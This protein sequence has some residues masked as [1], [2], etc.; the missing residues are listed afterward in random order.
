MALK[1][2]AAEYLAEIQHLENSLMS[3]RPTAGDESISDMT[4]RLAEYRTR[5]ATVT[6]NINAKIAA[7]GIDDRRDLRRIAGSKFLEL[8]M[9]ALTAKLRL[10][11]KLRARAFER[12]R[13]DQLYR[14]VMNGAHPPLECSCVAHVVA[15]PPSCVGPQPRSSHVGGHRTS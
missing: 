3:T 11:E 4:A 1:G 9:N 13:L 5:H 8:R 14:N 12:E 15:R 7:L 6:T 10:R 2:S